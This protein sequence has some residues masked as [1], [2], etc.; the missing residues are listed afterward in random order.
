MPVGAFGGEFVAV[1]QFSN[2]LFG[3]MP[4]TSS[5]EMKPFMPLIRAEGF[6]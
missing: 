4:F 6:S 2:D 5:H 1:A 3:R